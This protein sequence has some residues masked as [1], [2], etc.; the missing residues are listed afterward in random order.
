[1]YTT[2]KRR[3]SLLR[4]PMKPIIFCGYHHTGKTTLLERA[5]GPLARRGYRIGVVKHAAGSLDFAASGKDLSRYMTSGAAEVHLISPVP[6]G[7][8][9]S[10]GIPAPLRVSGERGGPVVPFAGLGEPCVE[11]IL[12]AS[13]ADFLFI[14]GFKDWRGP[15]PRIVF[16][17]NREE[18]ER[19]VDGN[20]VGYSGFGLEELFITGAR[21]LP[22]DIEAEA[23]AGFLEG[24]NRGWTMGSPSGTSNS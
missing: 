15:I 5:I 9:E 17:R 10:G 23:L 24:I 3:T 7:S 14:E 20:T 1:M 13:S 21:F 6:G 19:L 8:R 11:R 16:G 12:A 18:I 2:S 22:M 4:E